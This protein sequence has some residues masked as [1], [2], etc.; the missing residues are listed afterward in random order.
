M[1]NPT[2]H[3]GFTERNIIGERIGIYMSD[4]VRAHIANVIRAH[5]LENGRCTHCGERATF[6]SLHQADVLMDVFS[7]TAA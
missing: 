3:A 4:E 5:Q 2:Q 7:I 6:Q 1:T